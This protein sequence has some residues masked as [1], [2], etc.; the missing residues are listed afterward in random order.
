MASW[1]LCVY[2]ALRSALTK[3]AVY[4]SVSL[5]E[6]HPELS[7]KDDDF[8]PGLFLPEPPLHKVLAVLS[9]KCH[10]ATGYSWVCSS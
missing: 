7:P 10:V 3:E 6:T 2:T 9:G 5:E 8:P 1:G 4:C